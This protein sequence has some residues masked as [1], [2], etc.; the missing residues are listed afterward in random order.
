MSS[1]K[2]KCRE[3]SVA[4]L[5]NPNTGKST[6]FNALTGSTQRTGNYPGV[7]VERRTG[8]VRVDDDDFVLTDLPGTYSLS[9]RS[10]DELVAVQ[11]LIGN[12]VVDRPP[13]IL[14]CVVDASNLKRNL[15]LVSQLLDLGLPAVVALNMTDVAERRGLEIDIPQLAKQLGAEVIPVRANRSVGLPE[16]K[17]AL[18]RAAQRRAA[19]AHNPFPAAISVRLD[20]LKEICPESCSLKQFVVTRMLFDGDGMVTDRLT[21]L[22]DQ[23]FLDSLPEAKRQILASDQITIGEHESQARYHWISEVCQSCI[24]Q[25]QGA[26]RPIS[27]RIDQWLTHP[28]AGLAIALTVLTLLFLLVFWA[29]EPASWLI[30]TGKGW[31]ATQV[32]SVIPAGMFQSLIVNGLIE[33]VG[34]V[35]VFLP[36]ILLLFLILGILEDTGYLARA[37]FL[38]DGWL[39]RVGLSGVS[40][41]PLLSSFACA[42][43]GVMATRVIRDPRERLVTILIAPLM[44]CSARLPV[45]VLLVSAFVS[46]PLWRAATMMGLYSIGVV[47]AV[48]VAWV[49]RRWIFREAGTEFLM[50]LPA[51]KIP[52]A[53]TVLRRMGEGGWAFVRDAGTLIV[54]MTILV[55]A[56]GYFP[57]SATVVPAEVQEQLSQAT[58][59]WENLPKELAEEDPER[60]A[61]AER[62]AE[63]QAQQDAAYLNNSYLARLGRWIEPAVQPLGWDWRIGSAVIASFPAREVVVSTMGV[64][65]GLGGDTDENSVSL[66]DTL[67]NARNETTGA[68]L[69]TG[70]MAAG[71]LVF[72]ALCAQCVSTLAVIKRETNSWWWPTVTFV[73][74]TVLAY[75]GAWL[76]YQVGT[77]W[78][79]GA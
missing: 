6:L 41:I 9:P 4:V 18:Q 43:P 52:Q 8:R 33:G 70:P 71:L 1:L 46:H 15:F 30:D 16:L 65:F 55:W 13:D 74:M 76:T 77:W 27:E 79:G 54:A 29:A 12:E 44:S 72:F 78:G 42:I 57:R 34:G 17:R 36:Q 3:I 2:T 50:E 39:S 69:F 59:A 60:V 5:G 66:R 62:M 11:F 67:K 20:R 28:V 68:P 64:I 22:V 56:A 21:K 25:T 37:S 31:V 26:R 47:V 35:L 10:P 53:R 49:F 61:V 73:Y 40:L 32:E 58:L 14:L 24:R 45:Y 63:L 75:L 19:N 23:R 38:M 7:T 51:Y 48:G